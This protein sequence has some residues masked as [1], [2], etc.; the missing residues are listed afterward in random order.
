[1]TV[2]DLG[3][4]GS[5]AQAVAFSGLLDILQKRLDGSFESVTGIIVPEHGLNGLIFE[6]IVDPHPNKDIPAN[7]LASALR[8]VNA[9]VDHH[10][11]RSMV[12]DVE[13]PF[14]V[15]EFELETSGIINSSKHQ[16][17]L[18]CPTRHT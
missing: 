18:R 17:F 13:A 10:G 2:H 8:E 11:I 7:Y 15:G 12:A 9:L 1:M 14:C 6:L 4:E 5:Q 16:S 3:R